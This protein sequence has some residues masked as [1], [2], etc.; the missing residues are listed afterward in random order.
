MSRQHLSILSGRSPQFSS[1]DSRTSAQSTVVPQA[2]QLGHLHTV[3]P[4]Q[5]P[6]FRQQE[7]V[8]TAHRHVP[9]PRYQV[10]LRPPSGRSIKKLSSMK[11][12]KA[13]WSVER[14]P[15]VDDRLSRAVKTGYPTYFGPAH[16]SFRLYRAGLKSH[17]KIWTVK[18]VPK[19]GLVWDLG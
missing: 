18:I 13:K 6:I 9:S 14:C 19:P 15:S 17:D 4:R 16:S 3:G 2:P 10:N 8:E 11:R 1:S 5:T 12:L 7:P